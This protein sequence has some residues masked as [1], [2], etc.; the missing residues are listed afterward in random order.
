MNKIVKFISVGLVLATT[1]SCNMDLIPKGSISYEPGQQLITNK[2]DLD[3]YEANIMYCFRAIEYGTYDT[4]PDVMVDYFNAVSDFG[5]N[6]G[7]IHR[8][9]DTFTAGDTDVKFCWDNPYT[10][11]KNFNIFIEGAKTVPAELVEQAAVAR[12]EAFIARAFAY[13]NLARLFGKAYDP[14][15]ADTDLCVPLVTVYDQ[16]A[17]PARATVAEV[18]AQ[19]KEDLDSAAVLLAKVPGEVRAEKPTIDAVNFMYA[20]YYLDTKDYSK[21][22]SYAEKVLESEAGYALANTSALMEAEWVNDEGTEPVLQFYASPAEGVAGHSVYSNMSKDP[23]KGLYYKPYFIPS[24]K[25]IDAYSS[26]DLRFQQW[27]DGG[28]YPSFHNATWYNDG[29]HQYYVFNK[30]PGNPAL[31]SGT[32]VPNTGHAVKPFLIS[33]MYLIAAEAGLKVG[34]SGTVTGTNAL[35]TL[36]RARKGAVTTLT[37]ENVQNEWY[38]ETVGEGLRMSCLKRWNIGF[39]GRP[40]QKG[41][42][43]VANTGD[44]YN[45]RN[46]LKGDYHFQWPIPTYEIQTNLNLKQNE[47]YGVTSAE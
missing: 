44:Y 45:N 21:A 47:G 9:D 33:E 43:P 31:L 37:E 22:L 1:M 40:V 35:N 25:L 14:A 11:I 26:T 42:E 29:T 5:N 4:A 17:R 19:I 34:G 18:Y 16:S 27:F 3:G 46:M 13:M 7:P 2:A 36:Q 38:R 8:T 32:D 6:S 28:E 10:A 20:R 39:D 12:G 41:A 15:S 30:Y 23:Q 24:Q